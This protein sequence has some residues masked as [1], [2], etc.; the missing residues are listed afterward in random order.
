MSNLVEKLPLSVLRAEIL[1]VVAVI[2][3][4][5][6]A[7]DSVIEPLVSNLAILKENEPLSLV[8]ELPVASFRVT[9][10]ENEELAVVNELPVASFLVTRVEKDE[11]AV[12]KE[13]KEE[14]DEL[15]R[16]ENA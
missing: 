6:L 10:V 1:E 9:L 15:L 8:N 4:E 7:L 3:A 14:L 11:L 2:L 12:V 5:K 16:L 13:L